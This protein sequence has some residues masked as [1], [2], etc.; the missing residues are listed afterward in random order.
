MRDGTC[1][2][3]MLRMSSSYLVFDSKDENGSKLILSH[4]SL[5]GRLMWSH[6]HMDE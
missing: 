4:V 3:M 5:E 2:S 6:S 1:S